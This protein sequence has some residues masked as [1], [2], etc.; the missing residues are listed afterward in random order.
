MVE[1]I[2]VKDVMS[3]ELI[4]VESGMGIR[5]AAR[6][7]LEKHI[8]SL[9]VMDS[10]KVVGIVTD[11]DFVKTLYRCLSSSPMKCPAKVSEIMTKNPIYI[12]SN[13]HILQAVRLMGKHKIRHLIV[14]DGEDAKGIVSL[15]DVLK[16]EPHAIYG[17]IA[18]K[19]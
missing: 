4:S 17:Y 12:G 9:V 8:S 5:E 15:R 6:I 13:E 3:K 16:I 11:R 19:T 2:R 7:L 1:T 10:K 14:K 18:Q